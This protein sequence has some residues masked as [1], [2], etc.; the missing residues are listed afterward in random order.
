M[1]D[2][3]RLPEERLRTALADD[4]RPRLRCGALLSLVF[5]MVGVSALLLLLPSCSSTTAIQKAGSDQDISRDIRWE[6]RK[7]SRFELVTA[8]CAEGVITLEGR[9]ASKTEEG[10][11]LHLAEAHSHGY[12]VVSRIEVR[13]R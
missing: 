2:P 4:P 12:R 1:D 8:T 7:D 9:V 10:E 5:R 6:L 13:P 3:R 11:A